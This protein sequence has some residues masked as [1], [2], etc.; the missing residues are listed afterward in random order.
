MEQYVVSGNSAADLAGA[1]TDTSKE[2]SQPVFAHVG[3]KGGNFEHRASVR[4]HLSIHPVVHA[5]T[6]NV[7]NVAAGA[8][9]CFR[10][11]ASSVSARLCAE[12]MPTVHLYCLFTGVAFGQQ[13]TRGHLTI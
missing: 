5:F 3:A 7:T 1:F 2:L 8:V 9:H 10:L 11:R 4:E 12:S 13:L 6:F